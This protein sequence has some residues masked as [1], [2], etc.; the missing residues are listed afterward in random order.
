MNYMSKCVKILF[1]IIF[2]AS[3]RE[4]SSQPI[5]WQRTY[6]GI[7]IDYGYSIVQTPDEGYIAVGSKRIGTTTYMFAMRLNKYGDT[8]WTK[9]YSVGSYAYE[10]EK[11]SDGNFV[12]NGSYII[13]IDIN[14]NL[15]WYRPSNGSLRPSF[16]SGFYI[17]RED[18]LKKYNNDGDIIWDRNYSTYLINSF[19]TDITINPD[20]NVLLIGIIEDTLSGYNRF[21]LRAD[22]SG[23]F[24]SIRKFNSNY[25]P[26]KIVSIDNNNFVYTGVNNFSSFLVRYDTLCNLIWFKTYDTGAPEFVETNFLIKT[27]DKGFA[28]TGI[29]SS[30][31]FNYY[32]RILKTD[33]LGNEKWRKLYGF[34]DN[35]NSFCIRQTSDSGYVIIGI[36]DNFNLGDVY[37]VKTDTSGYAN[38]PVS[39]YNHNENISTDYKLFQ[40]YPNPFNPITTIYFYTPIKDFVEL[41]VY[42]L[43]GVEIKTLIK[44]ELENGY[45]K[46]DFDGSNL[47][48]GVYFCKIHTNNFNKT[49]KMSL[50]K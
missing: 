48:S 19:I 33:S 37:I 25:W 26:V 12:I 38:P 32:M 11:T 44:E 40:N 41:K 39:I 21:I 42:N 16:D 23:K 10:I 43:N 17:A 13:K 36:R 28:F 29:Y 9:T 3:G 50:I 1:L 2:F 22:D 27:N 49:I 5:T 14:G 20:H 35:D 46:I 18:G 31:N 30:G 47:S 24:L 15:I 4:V 45:H 6:G 34:N 8:I 7:N